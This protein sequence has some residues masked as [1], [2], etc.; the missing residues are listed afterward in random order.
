MGGGIRCTDSSPVIANNTITLNKAAWGQGI[1]CERSDAVIT[2]NLIMG[3]FQP[4]GS[5]DAGGGIFSMSGSPTI[6]YNR[7]IGN[8][9][10]SGGGIALY[11]SNA[12]IAYNLDPRQSGNDRRRGYRLLG[13]RSDHLQQP[14]Y[15]ECPPRNKRS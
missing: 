12:R 2:N 11:K 3:N 15:R 9:A 7:I 5:G 6:L 13:L 14:D 8:H 1:Y 10:P 4:G